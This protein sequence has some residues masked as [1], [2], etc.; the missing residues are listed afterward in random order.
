MN[1][2]L[3]EQKLQIHPSSHKKSEYLF[4]PTR[5]SPPSMHRQY[6][7]RAQPVYQR[8]Y[9]RIYSN[10]T[11]H[12]TTQKQQS[13]ESPSPQ[14]QPKQGFVTVLI[15]FST[16]DEPD[17]V[18]VEGSVKL[19]GV[20]RLVVG[21]IAVG[22]LVIESSMV[23]KCVVDASSSE[24]ITVLSSCSVQFRLTCGK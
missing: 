22:M 20:D 8:T 5:I 18:D 21:A 17:F 13:H 15:G 2:P 3:V 11:G 7:S 6:L 4:S 12:I 9:R 1:L 23:A 19:T 16:V 24:C 10:L 14:S